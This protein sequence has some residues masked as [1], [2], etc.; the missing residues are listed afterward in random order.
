MRS[1]NAAY[2]DTVPTNYSALLP[3]FHH[4]NPATSFHRVATKA[5]FEDV[6]KKPEMSN[7][8]DLQIVEL[9]MEMKDTPWRL[10]GQIAFRG[11]KARE[12]LE[13]EGFVDNVGEWVF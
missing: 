1:V 3:L 12:Y 13:Q 4:P 9:I 5:D 11:E 10:G 2:N 7:P 6:L 8:A